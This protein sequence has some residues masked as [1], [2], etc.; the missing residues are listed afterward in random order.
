MNNSE[1]H[2]DRFEELC[3][4]YV[5][6]ALDEEKQREFEAMMANASQKQITAYRSLRSAANNLALTTEKAEPSASVKKQLM[7]RI[8]EDTGQTNEEKESSSGRFKMTIAA[9]IVLLLGVL[10]LIGYSLTLNSQIND[11]QVTITRLQSKIQQKQQMLSVLSARTIDLII[12]KGLKVNPKGYGKIIWDAN[13]QQALLVVSNLPVVPSG[14]VYEL[15]LIKNNKPIPA[16]LFGVN[17]P[18]KSSFFKIQNLVKAS[19]QNASAFAVTLEPKGG[20]QKPTGDMYLLG[21][22]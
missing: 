15:W 11:Q 6:D 13:K 12:M 2:N 18:T 10:A 4:A 16:G 3:A 20:S 22:I 14:K 8:R 21:K 17:K 5:L 1:S 9:S 7:E 19:S